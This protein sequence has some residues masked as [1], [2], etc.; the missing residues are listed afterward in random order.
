MIVIYCPPCGSV[1]V[2]TPPHGSD[3]VR[4]I[5]IFHIFRNICNAKQDVGSAGDNGLDGVRRTENMAHT[6]FHLQ[7]QK[8]T[9]TLTCSEFANALH[10]VF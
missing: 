5:A 3:R 4:S 1:R 9:P 7:G 2:R 8:I 6:F 10:V